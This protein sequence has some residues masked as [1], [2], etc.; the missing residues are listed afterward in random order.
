MDAD[1]ISLLDIFERKARLEVPLFQRQYVW[2]RES[3]W[4]P[5]WED[6][7]RKFTEQI[8]E[9]TDSPAHF[10]GAMV[11]DQKHTSVNQVDRRQ[12]IDGQQRLT[13]FQV[14]LAVF[15][16]FA[17]SEGF[18]DLATE[19]DKFV[20]NTGKMADP[21][22]EQFKVWPTQL[23]RKQFSDVM[24][25]RSR[26]ALLARYPET[27]QKWARHPDPRPGMVE[28]YLFFS[29]Q[30]E[31][32][33]KGVGTE[34][35]LR[36]EIPLEKRLDACF[37]ALR[38]SLKVVAI[39][40]GLEDDPQVIFETLNARG[41]PLLP[42]DLMRNYIFLRASRQNEDQE[43]LYERYWKPFDDDFWRATGE[44]GR[45]TRPPSDL[46]M[47]Y[48]V[49]SRRGVD[50]SVKHLYVEY[51][52]W[53]ESEKPFP[54]VRDELEALARQGEDFKRLVSPPENDRLWPLSA[55]LRAF[56]L[57][58]A[59]PFLLAVLDSMP[60][61]TEMDEISANL[62]SFIVRRAISGL[63]TKNYNRVFL[64]LTRTLKG[65]RA[66][67]KLISDYLA[68]QLGPSVEWPTDDQFKTAWLS[69]PAYQNAGSARVLH[70]LR[71]LNEAYIGPK[72]ES[73]RFEIPPS[74]EHLLPQDWLEYWPLRD[75]RTGMNWQELSSAPADDERAISTR[76]RDQLLQSMG[77]LTILSQPLNSSIS[78]KPW[79]EKKEEILKASLLPINQLLHGLDS[80][81]EDSILSRGEALYQKAIN[82][83]KRPPA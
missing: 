39:G 55:F 11:L 46:F 71:R 36:A 10:L 7:A 61:E 16:D 62:E 43:A 35:P 27:R 22:V 56:D 68:A 23:D 38:S 52:Y 50:I 45:L 8:D 67:P 2:N 44:R 75:G 37:H 73:L 64:Q 76:K 59:Y 57:G 53:I 26:A 12:V 47:Q 30:L 42:A 15:R 82:I 81:D 14:F 40:L 19:C 80:W 24:L 34:P 58:T 29:D 48:F 31:G 4:E 9:T 65:K 70:V 32:F 74:V 17:Q 72:A 41:Q 83:W 13:T 78:N 6:I 1:A 33:L 25:S 51:K 60:T 21:G 18:A 63:T 79:S 20:L 49:S 66:T 28:A 54:K 69:G 5:L 3:Q 77:N